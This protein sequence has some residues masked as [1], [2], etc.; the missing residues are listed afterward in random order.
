MHSALRKSPSPSNSRT[1]ISPISGTRRPSRCP[2]YSSHI[3][4]SGIVT[5]EQVAFLVP[6]A[7]GD[8][9]LQAQALEVV[10]E[11][12]EE[13]G[14]R[15]DRRNCSTRPCRGSAR[16]SGAARSRCRKAACRTRR[17]FAAWLFAGFHSETWVAPASS[18]LSALSSRHMG[19]LCSPPN[20]GTLPYNS[21][22]VSRVPPVV[23]EL[24][25]AGAE[26]SFHDRRISLSPTAPTAPTARASIMRAA[27]SSA[28]PQ[29]FGR[30]APAQARSSP[31]SASHTD[32]CG[33]MQHR[34]PAAWCDLKPAEPGGRTFP[35]FR[36][37]L[38]RV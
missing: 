24:G 14:G 7:R 36:Q 1:P 11:V 5:A 27:P 2:L 29:P 34:R 12:M 17:S 30:V 9:L 20:L 23:G 26:T 15:G 33:F 19:R 8:E 25:G 16:C 38:T 3:A 32:W 21:L 35:H 22:L 4:C 13:V 37:G 6:V 31:A 10:R 28:V 18:P